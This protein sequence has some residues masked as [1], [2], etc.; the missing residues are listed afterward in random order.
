MRSCT[1]RQY[2]LRAIVGS[3]AQ[4]AWP[5]PHRLLLPLQPHTNAVFGCIHCGKVAGQTPSAATGHPQPHHHRLVQCS[6]W[7]RVPSPRLNTAR[8]DIE[9]DEAL[10]IA[11]CDPATFRFDDGG[12]DGPDLLAELA[13][14]GGRTPFDSLWPIRYRVSVYGDACAIMQVV[15]TMRTVCELACISMFARG[16][17][18]VRWRRKL[19]I[20]SHGA[21]MHIGGVCSGRTE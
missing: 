15:M 20:R 21:V 1:I 4:S 7:H 16:D 14:C 17:V 18:R 10:R 9:L 13:G 3:S 19:L 5:S 11:G 8:R 6:A 12:A 2:E